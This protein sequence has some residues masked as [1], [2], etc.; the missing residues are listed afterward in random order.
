MRQRSLGQET[1]GDRTV[2]GRN[3][4]RL[5][6][7]VF[8]QFADEEIDFGSLEAGDR[9]IKIWFN[10]KLLEFERQKCSIPSGI[11]GIGYYI[12]T[13]LSRG[14]IDAHGGNVAHADEFCCLGPA[15]SRNNSVGT[16]DEDRT[17]KSKFFDARCNLLDLLGSVRARIPCP[18]LQLVGSLYVTFN[19]AM[20]RLLQDRRQ[21]PTTHHFDAVTAA[22]Q[23]D[24]LVLDSAT[25][26]VILKMKRFPCYFL[27]VALLRRNRPLLFFSRNFA[28]NLYGIG[29]C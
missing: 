25:T 13:N 27:H 24:R 18:R 8:I 22:A 21:G 3:F 2:N 7:A 11:L 20:A 26:K 16:I 5:I 4:I 15:M 17:D 29:V 6:R 14:Q 28:R 9:D 1:A 10:R 23:R 19:A 12:G